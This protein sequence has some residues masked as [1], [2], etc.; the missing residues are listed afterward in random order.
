MRVLL[1]TMALL[2][3]GTS[4]EAQKASALYDLCVKNNP[5][6]LGYLSGVATVLVQMGSAYQDKSFDDAVAVPL[7]VFAICAPSSAHADAKTLRDIFVAWIETDPKRKDQP[8][9]QAATSAFQQTWPC[10]ARRL[11]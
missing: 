4:A 10:K 1:P 11:N 3:L 2:A 8:F 5:F 6:C 7:G 9:S